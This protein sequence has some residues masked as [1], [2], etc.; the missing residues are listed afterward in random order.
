MEWITE[1]LTL[2]FIG[3]LVLLVTLLAGSQSQAGVII[4]VASAVM[5]IIMTGLTTLTGA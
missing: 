1:G 4:Y 2:A 5:L 3:L